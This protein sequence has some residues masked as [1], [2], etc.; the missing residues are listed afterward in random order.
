MRFGR[1]RLEDNPEHNPFAILV[2]LLIFWG[3]LLI[4]CFAKELGLPAWL[5]RAIFITYGVFLGLFI[6]GGVVGGGAWLGFHLSQNLLEENRSRLKVLLL[7]P[8]YIVGATLIW[9]VFA[10]TVRS[11]A[12]ENP[13]PLMALLVAPGILIGLTV[14]VV[15]GR[16]K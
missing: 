14:G 9:F 5:P 1:R 7:L 15:R 8:A 16:R 3:G 12:V 6:V 10:F 2:G 4:A 13:L 11:T